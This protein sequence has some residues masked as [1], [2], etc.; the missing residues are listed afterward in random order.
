[1]RTRVFIIFLWLA[2]IAGFGNAYS[3]SS[4]CTLVSAGE[5]S[6]EM[7]IDNAWKNRLYSLEFCV[8]DGERKLVAAYTTPS[9][10]LKNVGVSEVLSPEMLSSPPSNV[11][12]LT[13]RYYRLVRSWNG[14]ANEDFF[15]QHPLMIR[16]P[17]VIQGFDH[18]SLAN[19]LDKVDCI[20]TPA[21]L[22]QLLDSRGFFWALLHERRAR[23]EQIK[24]GEKVIVEYIDTV[25]SGAAHVEFELSSKSSSWVLVFQVRQDTSL[26]LSKLYPVYD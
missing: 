19:L 1:M 4:E 18:T 13:S 6:E 14:P 25:V 15:L 10:V 16:L 8:M 11:N 3:V 9:V 21:C 2:S 23:V 26:R 17:S 5:L 24:S 22:N 20:E 7:Q 12:G